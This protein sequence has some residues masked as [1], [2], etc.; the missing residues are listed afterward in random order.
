MKINKLFIT[1]EY[2]NN[3][4]LSEKRRITSFR[5]RD[6]LDLPQKDILAKVQNSVTPDNFLGQGTEAEVYRIKGTKYCVR[7]PYLAQDIYRLYT[8]ELTPIDKVNH[9]VA[10]LGFGASIMKYF[11]GVI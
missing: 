8:K 6:L 11:E 4:N 5:S 1:P 7:I 9:V 2:Q 3:K 10:K